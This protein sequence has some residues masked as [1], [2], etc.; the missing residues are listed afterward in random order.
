M[1]PEKFAPYAVCAILIGTAIVSA[2]NSNPAIEEKPLEPSP[3]LVSE[4]QKKAIALYDIARDELGTTNVREIAQVSNAVTR[5]LKS[6]ELGFIVLPSP[7]AGLYT[8]VSKDHRIAYVDQDAKHLISGPILEAVSGRNITDIQR[9]DLDAIRLIQSAGS[10][11]SPQAPHQAAAVPPSAPAATGPRDDA[12][13]PPDNLKDSIIPEDDW[14]LSGYVPK[15]M[16]A[17][18][19]TLS[20]RVVDAVR[21]VTHA[22]VPLIK[23][24]LVNVDTV[25]RSQVAT[26]IPEDRL[27]HVYKPEGPAKYKMTVFADPTCPKCQELHAELPTLLEAGVEV[28]YILFPRDPNA[29]ELKH[30][31]EV[32]NCEA[33]PDKRAELIEKLYAGTKIDGPVCSDEKVKHAL[34]AMDFYRVEGTP[35]ILVRENGAVYPGYVPAADLLQQ[36]TPIKVASAKNEKAQQ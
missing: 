14:S 27:S 7:V 36:M 12:N 11:V 20:Q 5:N 23:A 34:N 3:P 15:N 19:Y 6:V 18:N 30:R 24:G 8:L 28:G 13:T 10:M 26:S 25:I 4:Y 35:T 33:D 29:A 21:R 1:K 2:V 9:A 32:A 16:T 31:I 22:Y 17:K